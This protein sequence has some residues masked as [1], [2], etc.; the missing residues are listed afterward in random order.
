M[1]HL[2]SPCVQVRLR[3]DR[4]LPAR[5]RRPCPPFSIAS[6]PRL[7]EF[8]TY[9]L[10]IVSPCLVL[11]RSLWQRP[12]E[13]F[14]DQVARLGFN[15]LRVPFSVQLALAMDTTTPEGIYTHNIYVHSAFE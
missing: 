15:A 8:H 4:Q 5:V 10:T 7:I 14:L 13:D 1:L 12:M 11:P 3:D 2:P 6:P 9:E